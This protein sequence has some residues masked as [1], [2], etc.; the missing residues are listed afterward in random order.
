MELSDAQGRAEMQHDRDFRQRALTDP[1][2]QVNYLALEDLADLDPVQAVAAWQR[3]MVAT[4]DDLMSGH[5]AA[6]AMEGGAITTAWQRAQFLAIRAAF[7]E[8][9]QPANGDERLLVD[10]L[11]QPT[12]VG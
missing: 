8:E 1:P 12:P 7:M 4:R 6:Q 9:W 3:V 5:R 2:E 11:A 10:M